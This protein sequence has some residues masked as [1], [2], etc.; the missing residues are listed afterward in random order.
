M[1]Q[2][3]A[4]ALSR[5][6]A[7]SLPTGQEEIW[8]YSRI[9]D[10]DLS[11]FSPVP[12][13]AGQ[14]TSC[15]DLPAEAQGLVDRVGARAGYVLTLDGAI[16]R[17]DLDHD[18]QHSG[19]TLGS[20][21]GNGAAEDIFGS[22]GSSFPAEDATDALDDLAEAFVGDGVMVSV[23]A[24]VELSR[25]VVIVNMLAMASEDEVNGPAAFPR[26]IVHLGDNSAAT[27]IELFVSGSGAA[28]VGPATE[29]S[30]GDG[31]RLS[32]SVVQQLGSHTWQL[33]HS[34]ARTGR[35]STLKC[36]TASLGGEYARSR[37]DS[38]IDGKGGSAEL[39]AA[40]LGDG[41]Q[42]HDFRTLQEHSAPRT[43]SDL[44]FKGAVG[45]TARSVYSGMIRMR[46]GARGA[47][48]FQTNRN[49]VL[50][51]GAHADSVP[52]LD[53]Q[54]NDVRCSHASAV[55][56]IDPEQ[57]F[58]LESRGVPGDVA[59]RLILLGFFK[60]LLERTEPAV[61]EHVVSSIR[62]RLREITK[63]AVL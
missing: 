26:L 8:R 36:F 27:V 32:Y 41:K 4:A 21:S 31:A 10:L 39:L 49:L 2:R 29:L 63:A 14:A 57:R 6:Q 1:Q 33:G 28:L 17:A 19:V 44:V 50:S 52:N 53:I 22:I 23:P 56:P 11:R 51:D 37:L 40:Y 15:P 9:G 42:V 60:E 12:G 61:R 58:Y 35:D 25:P 5:Y 34:W 38:L 16:C 7:A 18:S 45:G 62:G 3:R 47:N 13:P 55:G 48:A 43:T 24:G 20:I 46:H 30:V 59:E 54:E